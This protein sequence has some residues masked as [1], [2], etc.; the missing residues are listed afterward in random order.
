L[1]YSLTFKP[2]KEL[3]NNATTDQLMKSLQKGNLVQVNYKRSEQGEKMFIAANPKERNILVYDADLRKQFQ[4][5]KEHKTESSEVKEDKSER[6]SQKQSNKG[7]TG[8]SRAR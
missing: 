8:G 2:V 1:G 4:G 7:Y 6:K 5:I 3:G